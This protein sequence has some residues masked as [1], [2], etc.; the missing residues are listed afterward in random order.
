MSS[1]FTTLRQINLKALGLIIAICGIGIVM[2]YSAAGGSVDPWAFKQ[3][4][5][6]FV[7][8][9]ILIIMATV[10]IQVYLR[11]AYFFY[12]VTFML[13]LAVEILG[14]IGM[15][16][17]RW[18]DLY[19]IQLQPS[20]LMKIALVMA[21]ARYFLGLDVREFKKPKALIFPL[22]MML[23]PAFLVMKQPDLGTA[24][25]ILMVGGCLLFMAGISLWFFG[26]AILAKK[27]TDT[28]VSS[29]ASRTYLD[30]NELWNIE[31][32]QAFKFNLIFSG[33]KNAIEKNL[34]LTDDS[35]A[36]ASNNHIEFITGP[37]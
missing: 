19:V 9:G 16:A 32:P 1:T 22:L 2:L 20:E 33:Y 24:V 14:F 23:L 36:L 34:A 29:D 30:R 7:G 15:G 8:V 21:M 3:S 10:D 31:T 35:S 12:G 18:I 17:Q 13:L 26:A 4:I 5:R 27:T 11:S 28:I 6:F 25:V 37:S